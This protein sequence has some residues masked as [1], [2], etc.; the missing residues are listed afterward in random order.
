MY[1]NKH[2]ILN[3]E[4]YASH[5]VLP[6]GIEL[7][8]I[9]AGG[10]NVTYYFFWGDIILFHGT[11]YK[12]SFL[13]P[14][15]EGMDSMI[16]LLSFLTAKRGDADEEYFKAYTE[17]QTAWSESETCNKLCKYVWQYQNKGNEFYQAALEYFESGFG[18]E[19]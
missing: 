5:L 8:L 1:T 15:I 4:N 3:D 2:D 7:Y 12:P 16:G 10:E 18:V 19:I 17:A 9:Y 13:Y 11:D 6:D 14:S